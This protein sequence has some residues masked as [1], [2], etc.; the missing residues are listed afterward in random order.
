MTNDS[1]LSRTTSED[2][3]LETGSKIWEITRQVVAA[4]LVGLITYLAI[5]R[6]RAWDAIDSN[7][8]MMEI[9]EAEGKTRHSLIDTD[10]ERME[11]EVD[12][13]SDA[14]RECQLQQQRMLIEIA[15]LPPDIWEAKILKNEH[16]ITVIKS[17]MENRK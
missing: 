12:E 8:H 3:Q 11:E 17:L 14:V 4:L 15:K 2:A 7:R 13:L 10:M 5:D 1:K 16:D 6:G 9:H